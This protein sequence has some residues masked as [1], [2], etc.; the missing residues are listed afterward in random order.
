MV[1]S[2]ISRRP[3]TFLAALAVMAIVSVGGCGSSKSGAGSAP[4]GGA[5][6][7]VAS[8]SPINIGIIGAYTGAT[9]SA[10]SAVRDGVQAWVKTVNASGGINGHP[11]KAFV[12]DDKNDPAASTQALR[13]LVE[14]DHVV[15]LVGVYGL[16]TE[17]TW[18]DYLVAHN[19]PVVGG[20]Q[21][22]DTWNTNPMF[23]GA[24]FGLK[25]KLA[26]IL[27]GA[28]D[29]GGTKM[30]GMY[31][32]EITSCV[33]TPNNLKTA[34]PSY[35]IQWV[36]AAS[37]SATAANYSGLCLQAKATGATTVSATIPQ[38]DFQ[39]VVD[40]CHQQGFDPIWVLNSTVLNADS[41]KSS[42]LNG[43]SVAYLAAVPVDLPAAAD[44]VAAMGKYYPD[45]N[46]ST[47]EGQVGWTG[48]ILFQKALKNISPTA[49]VTSA[50]V[51]NGLNT[52]KNDNLGGL[53]PQGITFE[54]GVP[55][56]QETCIFVAHVR[57]QK[58]ESDPQPVC[59]P[60]Q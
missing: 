15:A 22:G 18:S 39:R 13:E 30:F 5:G 25:A 20:A 59:G 14:T 35:G 7:S 27:A 46:L 56:A 4:P 53:L 23:F 12:E 16:G 33:D 58:L 43:K 8:G 52:I 49:T 24:S 11:I 10:G 44:Y 29:L 2:L 48:G 3:K 37:V 1:G 19:V 47:T 57:N 21:G 45:V 34:A 51:I 38:S 32:V 31:C 41:L 26:G 55:H 17:T 28:K 50:D 36:G 42:S 9:G 6:S 54:K 60:S 40:A